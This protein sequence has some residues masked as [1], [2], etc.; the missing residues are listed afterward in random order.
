MPPSRV[1]S[2][3]SLD[4]LVRQLTKRR[5]LAAAMSQSLFSEALEAQLTAD[6]S[7]LLDS[8]A[9]MSAAS[10]MSYALA[11]DACDRLLQI[12]RALSRIANGR[13]GNCEECG[14]AIA[15]RRLRALPTATSCFDCAGL[16]RL[17]EP[18][19]VGAPGRAQL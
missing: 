12:D 10:E 5:R 17:D 6:R 9:P 7:D 15:F 19:G 16:T 13:Y 4:R 8:D 18:E 2:Q 1:L 11:A 14:E 3:R